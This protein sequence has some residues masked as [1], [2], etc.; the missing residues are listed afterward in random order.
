M[1][2]I[3]YL[4]VILLICAIP[5]HGI[6][7]PAIP[8]LD[9]GVSIEE[10]D[11]SPSVM[12]VDKIKVTNATLTDNA[13]GTVS[14]SI[15]AGAGDSVTVAG[16]AV[17][18][19]AD[20]VDTGIVDFTL[21]DGGAG[22]PD[23]IKGDIDA[24]GIDSAHYAADSIDNEHINWGD[25][26]YLGNEGAGVNEAYA[27]GWNGDVGPPE[28]DD[29]YDYLVNFDSDADS[30]FTDETWFDLDNIGGTN[31]AGL[32]GKLS[33]VADLYEA[34]GDT[35]TGVHDFGG[36]TSLEVP[37]TAGDVTVNAAGEVA[38]DSTQR[39]FVF[40]DGTAEIAVPAIHT[41]QASFDLAGMWDVEDEWR[42]LELKSDTFPDGIV[43]TKWYLDC[44]AADPTTEFA[45]DL[46]RCNALGDGAFP[47]A[48]NT[49]IDIMDTTTGN[50]KEETNTNMESNGVVATGQIIYI[51]MD[52][53][54]TDANTVWM[55]T[56]FFYIPES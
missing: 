20:F 6:K 47:H 38:V 1:K 49:V 39:Q 37:N 12:D 18:T 53:D 50:S 26:D 25:I 31:K 55:F 7:Q 8:G 9:R 34:D 5:A 17:D 51:H 22:G 44:D 11:G 43:I 45:G 33:D 15:G 48:T 23:T 41:L 10:E 28:K 27:V 21:T 4:I 56:M 42:I 52:S 3:L 40:Y 14:I 24:D 54:P 16:S 30:S 19:T 32:E 46:M 35:P 2:K 13:D 29:I 36:A